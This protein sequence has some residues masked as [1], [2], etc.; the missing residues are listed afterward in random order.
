[1]TLFLY[2]LFPVA[3]LA[4]PDVEIEK[5]EYKTMMHAS[6]FYGNSPCT[7]NPSALFSLENEL[8]MKAAG[9][10]ATSSGSFSLKSG[11]PRTVKMYD[12]PG[13][14]DLNENS[15]IFRMRQESGQSDWEGTL[16]SRS[17]DRYHTT[18][19]RK[20]MNRCCNGC[21]ELGGKMEEDIN[22]S[23]ASKFSYSHKCEIS[24]SRNINKL[25]DI[26]HHWDEMEMVFD[27]LGW[28]A[29]SEIDIVSDL[30]VTECVYE[31]FE[32]DFDSGGDQEVGE[33]AVTLWYDSSTGS[34]PALAEVSFTI[35]SSGS[36]LEDWNEATIM[37]AHLFWDEMASLTSLDSNSSTKTAW[38]Y[39]YDPNWCS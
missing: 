4:W 28:S 39:S 11:M 1:M 22:L 9:A 31:G 8:A 30:T 18:Y 12:T 20:D 13:S 6:S 26:S 25:D 34:N 35:T 17:G 27:D 32:V 21:T 33:F 38:V 10:G 23:W 16:K 5:R 36:N 15:W 7:T 3:I 37:T 2:A 19:R 29:E 14:C 24:S